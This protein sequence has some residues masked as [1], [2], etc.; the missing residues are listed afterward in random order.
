M[1]N[2]PHPNQKSKKTDGNTPIYSGAH[3]VGYVLGEIFSKT[4]TGIKHILRQPPAI[5]FDLATLD[6]A[7]RA[8]A[9][10][11]EV[12]DRESGRIYRAPLALVRSAGFTLNRGFDLQIALTLPYFSID[13]QP[14]RNAPA[15]PK[16]AP[17]ALQSR[18]F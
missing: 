13:G 2:I 7:A 4:I 16:A 15:K 8:G 12:K 11:V 6:D 14:P 5:A 9:N 18:L 10:R 3:I 17:E 1:Q